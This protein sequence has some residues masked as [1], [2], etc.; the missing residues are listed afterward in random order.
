MG[1]E[2]LV[3]ER[4][5]DG[6]GGKDRIPVQIHALGDGQGFAQGDIDYFC[7]PQ[8]HHA[9]K[10]PLRSRTDGRRAVAGGQPAVEGGRRAAAL[11]MPEHGHARFKALLLDILA[12]FLPDAAQARHIDGIAGARVHFLSAKRFGAFRNCQQAEF[13]TA[14]GALDGPSG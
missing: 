5:P 10:R 4:N 11:D 8:G 1:R 9:A 12:N 2:L 13:R 3:S 6:A 7:I 14:L